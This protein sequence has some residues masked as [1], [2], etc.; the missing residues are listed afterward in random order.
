MSALLQPE[1]GPL[2]PGWE[3]RFTNDGRPYYVDHTTR[4]TSWIKPHDLPYRKR[5]ENFKS[6]PGMHKI[7][8]TCDI[9]IRRNMAFE[10]SFVAIMRCSREDMRRMLVVSLEGEDGLDYTAASTSVLQSLMFT[11][12]PLFS[13]FS[14]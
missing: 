9:K 7:S 10:D 12:T 13:H 6:Q 1:S 5:L 8:G 14:F 11:F 3:R 4:T 2:P